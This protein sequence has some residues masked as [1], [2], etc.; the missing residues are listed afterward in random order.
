MFGPQAKAYM[1]GDMPLDLIVPPKRERK[2]R[3]DGA[4]N[5]VGDPLFEALRS[6]RRDIALEAGVPPYVIFHDATLR[7]MAMQRPSSMSAMSKISGVGA[8]KL[9]EYGAAFLSVIQ[10]H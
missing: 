3:R 5:P 2:L 10:Q 4:I 7:E 1:K 6:A 8:R 9:D